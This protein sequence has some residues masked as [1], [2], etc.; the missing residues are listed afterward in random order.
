[1]P[2][3][4]PSPPA[5]DKI[6]MHGVSHISPRS[7]LAFDLNVLR[8]MTFTSVALPFTDQTALG[9]YLKRCDVRVAAND[10]LQSTWTRGFAQIANGSEQLSSDDVNVVL[11]DAY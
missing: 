4:R 1:M 11:E 10:P 6:F 3:D 9:T 2:G 7:W 8:R 5:S